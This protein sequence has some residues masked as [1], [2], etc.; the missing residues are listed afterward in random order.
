MVMEPPHRIKLG[1]I[2]R[3][4]LMQDPGCSYSTLGWG[5]EVEESK[6]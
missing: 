1:N 5:E 6:V 3:F 4:P 2:D